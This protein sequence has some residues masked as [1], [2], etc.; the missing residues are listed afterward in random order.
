M[1]AGAAAL[2]FI[3]FRRAA[4]YM[5]GAAL[6]SVP[7]FVGANALLFYGLAHLPNGPAQGPLA[8]PG[9]LSAL[10]GIA[11]LGALIAVPLVVSGLGVAL[12]A[13]A[14]IYTTWCITRNVKT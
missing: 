7:G 9:I 1:L 2:F 10:V 6:G 13:T 5:L 4:L 14:G 11:A 8:V 12:G 3:R